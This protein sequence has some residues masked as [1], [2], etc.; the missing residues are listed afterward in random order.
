MAGVRKIRS[1][2]EDLQIQNALFIHQQALCGRDHGISCELE[3]VFP[4]VSFTRG[5][6]IDHRQLQ[7]FLEE[8]GS[9]FCDLP[10]HTAVRQLSCSKVICR[11]YKLQNE[12]DV[13]LTEKRIEFI[14]SCLILPDCQR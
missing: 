14:H 10:Y 12:I 2:L 11:F 9:A 1:Q 13:F 5:H 7:A 3:P 8:I 4:V 6:A